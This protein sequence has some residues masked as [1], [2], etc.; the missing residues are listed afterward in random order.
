MNVMNHMGQCV[1]DLE[2]SRA[3]YEEA[4]GFEFWRLLELGDEPSNKLLRL[5]AP[6]GF[7]ACYLRAGPF[8]LELLHFAGSGAA[9][10]PY[11][12]RTMNEIGITHMSLSVDDI[13]ATCALVEQHGGEVLADTDI[14]GGALRPGSRRSADRAAPHGVRRARRRGGLMEPRAARPRRDRH[15]LRV[16]ASDGRSRSTSPA[17]APTSC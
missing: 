6:L 8:V 4:L 10:A 9:P 16:A 15:R 2:R 14:G 12:E 5:D 3:F 11:R 7:R 13:P 17:R 1:T